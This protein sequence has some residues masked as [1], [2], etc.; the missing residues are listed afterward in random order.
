MLRKSNC[1]L[2]LDGFSVT[3]TA[4]NKAFVASWRKYGHFASVATATAQIHSNMSAII[5]YAPVY[6]STAWVQ[7]EIPLHAKGSHYFPSFTSGHSVRSKTVAISQTFQSLPH[8]VL[9]QVM[10][11]KIF[12]GYLTKQIGSC[13]ARA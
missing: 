12:T 3:S 7:R 10:A 8:Q 9:R 6:N 11:L 4:T 5:C 13:A 2:T 1:L